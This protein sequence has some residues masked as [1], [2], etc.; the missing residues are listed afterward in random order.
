[1]SEEIALSELTMAAAEN[2]AAAATSAET[3]AKLVELKLSGGGGDPADISLWR[4][5][6]ESDYGYAL[7][8]SFDREEEPVGALVIPDGVERIGIRKFHG[9]GVEGALTIPASVKAVRTGAFSQNWITSVVFNGDI[10]TIGK[11]A[12]A[13][14]D[15]LKSVTFPENAQKLNEIS[16]SCFSSCWGLAQINIP[17]SVVKIGNDA[18]C[19]TSL[20]EVVLHEGIESIGSESFSG[21]HIQRVVFPKS[22]Q[23][24]GSSAFYGCGSLS[25]V[26]FEEPSN[27]TTLPLATF[28]ESTIETVTLP[29][30]ITEIDD[31]CFAVC[32][33]LKTVKF[34]SQLARIGDRAFADDYSLEDSGEDEK[35]VLLP[36]SLTEIGEEA[37]RGCEA[38]SNFIIQSSSIT[39]GPYAFDGTVGLVLFTNKTT[40]EVQAMD[41]CPWGAST[42]ICSDGPL[43]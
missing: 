3:Q 1:M 27:L 18:F 5:A 23:S 30:S 34:S 37:F 39:I 8:V 15:Y 7:N 29:E 33:N 22:I 13:K 16:P 25:E 32:N 26:V 11:S 20:S 21:A 9:S 19:N 12:F 28:A 43:T 2:N 6:W 40:S 14:C 17:K 38:V 10:E 31:E 24:I 36:S 42:I 41:N 35:T 4:V